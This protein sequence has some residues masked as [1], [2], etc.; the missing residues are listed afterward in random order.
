MTP[1]REGPQESLPAPTV[2]PKGQGALPTSTAAPADGSS[3]SLISVGALPVFA[4]SG[5]D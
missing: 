5:G 2:V 4:A 1:W 3:G